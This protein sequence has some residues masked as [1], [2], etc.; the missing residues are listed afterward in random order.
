MPIDRSMLQYTH[1]LE[2]GSQEILGATGT[3]DLG[4]QNEAGQ[5]LTVLPRE[6]TSHSKHP[7]PKTQETALHIDRIRWSIPRLIILFG[8]ED[9]EAKYRQQEQNPELAVAQII[10]SSLQ[11]QV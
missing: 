1:V 11:N 2:V 3:F 7:L 4:I 5:K 9:G 10:R 8:A 6:H